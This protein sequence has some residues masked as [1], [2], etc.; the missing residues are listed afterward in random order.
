M[1]IAIIAEYN[2]FHKGHAYQIS[3]ARRIFGEDVKISVILGGIFSQRGE[4]YIAPPYIR[5]EAA[6]KCGADIVFEMPFPFSAAPASIFARAGVEIAEKIGADIL[7]FGS[8]CGDINKLYEKLDRLDSDEMKKALKEK[9]A[10][11]LGK[12]RAYTKVFES[13][14]GEAAPAAPNDILAIEYMRAI[15]NSGAKIKPY[16]I[17]RKGDYKSGA[18]EF[19]SASSL[20]SEFSSGGISAIK[21]GIP[22]EAYKV[23]NDA[24]ENGLLFPD[25]ERLASAVLMKFS[26]GTPKDIAFSGSGIIGRLKNAAR[27][28]NSI[29]E[30]LALASTKRYTDAELSRAVLY[31]LFSVK[32]SHLAKKVHYTRLL[33]ANSRGREILSGN[34]AIETVTKPSDTD[35][36]SASAKK[37]YLFTFAAERAYSLCLK[38]KYMHLKQ[39]PRIFKP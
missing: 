18:G 29:K 11:A 32:R 10:G 9:S 23:F 3:E 15:K 7:F 36:L 17:L 8:E 12:T 35:K 2:P 14:Y 30:L 19:P 22:D 31:T 20:R 26:D 5:A 33:A 34:I 39:A 27:E 6:I 38:G 25:I 16:T 1:H 24:N 21:H 4:A 28:A 13:L 37:Q